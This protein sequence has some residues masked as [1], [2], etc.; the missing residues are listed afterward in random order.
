MMPVEQ[1][2]SQEEEYVSTPSNHRP[3][4]GRAIDKAQC[5]L[6]KR[7]FFQKTRFDRFCNRCKG[8]NEVYHYSEWLPDT[9]AAI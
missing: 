9:E 5:H 4:R 7:V 3:H 8:G 2:R 6:C 1:N